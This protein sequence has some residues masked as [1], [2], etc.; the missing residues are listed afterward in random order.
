MIFKHFD[1]LTSWQVF[2]MAANECRFD[3]FLLLAKLNIQ[4][5]K[6]ASIQSQKM[7]AKTSFDVNL[8]QGNRSSTNLLNSFSLFKTFE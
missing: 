1:W 5:E 4:I 2:K 8:I 7:F 3:I 6:T